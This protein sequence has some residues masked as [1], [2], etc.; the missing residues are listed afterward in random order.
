MKFNELIKAAE[1]PLPEEKEDFEVKGIT[2][3]SRK[4]CEGFIFVAIEGSSLNGNNFLKDALTHKAK[5]IITREQIS[6]PGLSKMC[7]RVMDTRKVLADLC[8]AFRGRPSESMKV[9][10][11]TGTNGKTTVSYLIEA[12]LKYARHE[13]GV[14]GTINYR[15]KN[16]SFQADNTTPGSEEL[17]ALLARMLKENVDYA[18]ME[19]S[20]HA[21]EQERVRAVRFNS[22]I[23]TNL[24]VDHLDYHRDQDSYFAAKSKLFKQISEGGFAILNSD[25]P[26]AAEL[27]RLTKAKKLTYGLNNQ[28][29]LSAGCLRTGLDGTKLLL[30]LSRQISKDFSN[31]ISSIMLKV[32]LIGKHNIYNLLAAVAFAITQGIDIEIIRLALEGFKGVPGRLERVGAGGDF[33]VLVD[34]AHTED[35]LRNVISSLRPLCKGQIRVVFG[36]GGGRDKSKRPEMGKVATEL[37]HFAFITS[38]NPRNEEPQ[39]IIDDIVSGIEKKNFKVITDRNEAIKEALAQA[40]KDD[41]ILIAGKGH[42]DY[43]IFKDKTIHFDDR[44]VALEYLSRQ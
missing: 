3:D 25:D 26:R 43:Q 9:V 2:S 8:A 28:A 27:S 44:E 40:G 39:K 18:I 22:A 1:L 6:E 34:Y 13:P 7:R 30:S 37:A 29:D 21:L 23:F 12:I 11:I 33:L 14:I 15:F 36:C 10:G 4:V 19:V 16:K 32:P 31:G 38:D 42:E 5:L 17:Q 20:S 35:A 24:A 41:I